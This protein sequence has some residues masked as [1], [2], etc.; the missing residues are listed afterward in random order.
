VYIGTASAARES[1]DVTSRCDPGGDLF[2]HVACAALRQ[3]DR[4]HA[5]RRIVLAGDKTIDD[6]I[7]AAAVGSVSTKVVPVLNL[8][9][10]KY[11]SPSA[12]PSSETRDAIAHYYAD[13]TPTDG[14]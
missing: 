6:V 13:A 10:R 7:A 5:Q 12:G 1:P 9:S 2:R 11:S 4:D 3:V 8:Q 14:I